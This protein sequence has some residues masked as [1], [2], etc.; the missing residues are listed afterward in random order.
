MREGKI[1]GKHEREWRGS[2]KER[3]EWVGVK[4]D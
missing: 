3:E 4:E 2:E 1:S